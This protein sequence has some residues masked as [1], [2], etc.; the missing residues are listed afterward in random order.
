MSAF[1]RTASRRVL[2]TIACFFL[3]SGLVRLGLVAWAATEN[4]SLVPQAKASEQEKGPDHSKDVIDELLNQIANRSKELDD[5]EAALRDREAKLDIAEKVITQ[6][7]DRLSQAERSLKETIAKVD[8]ASESDLDQLT[9]MYASMKPKVA[10]Q[11]FEQ[12][13]PEFAAGFLARMPADAAGGIMS[14]LPPDQAYAISVV[15]AGR[16]ANAPKE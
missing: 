7:L 4:L 14:G 6:N 11:L 10:S 8:G 1:R 16:N 5:R 3:V 12:M 15:L 2:T 13:T 9:R